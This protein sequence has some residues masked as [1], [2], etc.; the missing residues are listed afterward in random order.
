MKAIILAAGKGTRVRPLTYTMPKPMIPIINKPVME[1]LV[2]HLA[3]H[4]VGEI[5]V[6]T[7]YLAPAIE[8]YFRDGARFGVQMAYSFEGRWENGRLIDEPVGSAGAIKKIQ[9]HSGFFDDTFF[10]L[11]GD[12]IIDL[13][14]TELLEVHRR[15]GALV[16]IALADVP[17]S[18]VSSYGVVVTD[19]DG[20]ILEF[21]EKPSVEEARSTTVNTGIYVF[22]PE[23]IECIPSGVEYDIGGELFPALTATGAALYGAKMPFQWLDIGKITDYYRVIQMALRGEIR[24]FA[25]PG[26]EVTEGVWMGL[27]VRADLDRCRITPPVYIGGS[28]TLEPGCTLIGPSFIGPGCVIESGA[29]IE[30]SVVFDYTRI[31]SAA[32]LHE[33]LVCGGYSVDASGTVIDLARADI[34]WVIADARMPKRPLS[35][36]QR[37]FLAMLEQW[38]GRIP[39]QP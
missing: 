17:R 3:R 20:R 32:H 37:Q 35:E 31:G 38:S 14:L 22:E 26:T 15:K 6:N 1:I 27:N 36:E 34:D 10:V 18:E 5:M 21:Q 30:R 13:N 19:D 9:E 28:A 16:T 33:M 23:V 25:M 11:C 12:A 7:S 2:E 8:N 4:G 24:G 29:H 39:A